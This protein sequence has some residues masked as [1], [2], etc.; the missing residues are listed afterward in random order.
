VPSRSRRVATSSPRVSRPPR[1]C[2]VLLCSVYEMLPFPFHFPLPWPSKYT[3]AAIAPSAKAQASIRRQSP[4]AAA[5][6]SH[7]NS[8]CLMKT[9]AGEFFVLILGAALPRIVNGEAFLSERG[10]LEQERLS[11]AREAFLSGSD[12]SRSPTFGSTAEGISAVT[13][14]FGESTSDNPLVEEGSQ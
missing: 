3:Q 4:G 10:F 6:V 7:E 12:R 14:D 2:C 1:M 13:W 8:V 9:A 11:W 5:L